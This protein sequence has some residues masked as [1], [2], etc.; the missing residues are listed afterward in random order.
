MSISNKDCS[1]MVDWNMDKKIVMGPY[2]KYH[3]ENDWISNSCNVI[4]EV[5]MIEGILCHAVNDIEYFDEEQYDY[6]RQKDVNSR[7]VI[8]WESIDS[9]Q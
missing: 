3:E 6:S 4:G 7:K 1:I 9:T 8:R 2:Y 5:R